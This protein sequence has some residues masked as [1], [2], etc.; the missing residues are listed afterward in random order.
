MT[1]S[2]H[3]DKK[4]GETDKGPFEAWCASEQEAAAHAAVPVL[5]NLVDPDVAE[6]AVCVVS[7]RYPP[8][9]GHWHA[10]QSAQ[11]VYACEGMLTIHTR[12]GVWIVPPHRAVWLPPS[13]VHKVAAERA[14]HLRTLY[15]KPGEAATPDEPAVVAVD[16]LL[17]A[18]LAE[19]ATYGT[20]YPLGGR[21]ERLIAVI[22]DRLPYL[23]TVPSYLPM[24]TD[25]R[26]LRLTSLLQSHPADPRTLDALATACG[27]TA[28]TAA[29]LFARETGLTFAQWRQQLRLLKGMQW[30][31]Q[32]QSVTEVA[33]EAG[34][35][36]V[37]AFITVF[38]QA[39]GDTPARYFR[40]GELGR[41]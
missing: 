40:R 23:A 35:Q 28:R 21:E 41:G 29:R 25:A 8:F 27:M 31:S 20:G 2:A 30:L 1:V 39:F 22:L 14:V 10:H 5:P 34:Y 17:D 24:P 32:G 38:K 16:P 33:L 7:D 11:F 3:R 37:S 4:Y 13:M 9:D 26:L 6:R 36:D 18:L 19:A 12:R 15:V